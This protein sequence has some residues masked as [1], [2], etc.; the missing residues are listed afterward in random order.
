MFPSLQL[1]WTEWKQKTALA[2]KFLP[3]WRKIW[4]KQ[5]MMEN[6]K[7]LDS[8]PKYFKYAKILYNVLFYFH[9]FAKQPMRMRCLKDRRLPSLCFH[10]IIGNSIV[11]VSE[12]VS[13]SFLPLFDNRKRL[14]FTQELRRHCLLE[15][16]SLRRTRPHWFR[17]C[18][19]SQLKSFQKLVKTNL[20]SLNVGMRPSWVQTGNLPSR[21]YWLLES[22]K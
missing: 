4:C 9:F 8:L 16:K 3:F 5:R 20:K 14:N 12:I 17:S 22:I 15:R 19:V 13:L 2:R 7:M 10:Y 1:Y 18:F 21:T 11:I 6:T